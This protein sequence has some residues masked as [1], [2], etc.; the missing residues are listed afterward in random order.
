MTA[1]LLLRER[2]V[3]TETAFVEV[4]V[5][6]LP[7]SLPGSTH[8]YKYRLALIVD[9]VCVLR[10]DNETGKGDHKHAGNRE[11][12]YRFVSLDALQRDF[13]AEVETW[14]KKQ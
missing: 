6:Q 11:A 3:L 5:W 2:L 10:Y 8:R 4:V 1:I 13:W 14:S 12:P 7:K 9:R